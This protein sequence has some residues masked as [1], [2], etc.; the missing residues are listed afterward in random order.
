MAS[1]TE[2]F[3]GLSSA[4]AKTTPARSEPSRH[5]P[6][7]AQSQASPPTED[8]IFEHYIHSLNP[9]DPAHG[10]TQALEF[11]RSKELAR[12]LFELRD[13][14]MS[15]LTVLDQKLRTTFRD[16][17]QK[18]PL[19]VSKF[20][21]SIHARDTLR[22]L[23]HMLPTLILSHGKKVA[24]T[25]AKVFMK[26][27]WK[28]VWNK[29][30]SQGVVRQDKLAQAPQTATT[31]STN[32]VDVLAQKYARAGNLSKASQTICSTLI[33]ALKP[34]TLDKLKAKNPQDSTDFDSR[35]WPTA[36]EIDALRRDHVWQKIEAESFS[37]KKIKQFFARC[38]PL[39]A[40][41]VDSWRPREHIAWMLND[42][43][44]MFHDF[45]R[46]QLILHYVQ[47][48]FYE[49]HLS[50]AVGGKFFE[51]ENPNDSVRLVVIS[52]TWR[53]APAS[54]SVAEV[55]SDVANFL[56][57][58]YDNFLQFA[59]QKNGVTRCAQ[60][61]QLVASNWEAQTVDNPLVVMQLDIINMFCSVKMQAQFDVL[62]E[63]ASTSYDNGN[64]RD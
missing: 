35:H 44:K 32:Q 22:Y 34:D 59:C 62:A 63:M 26:G 27:D 45:I 1:V 24:I 57:S 17:L 42:E 10:W 2:S 12:E 36:E 28:S 55:N 38:S 52:S 3:T 37:I 43:D 53:R 39:S 41:D 58:T 30:R 56:M 11:L 13:F 51:L 31:R 47:G 50:E 29:C 25:H 61:T 40:Q 7:S 6:L 49:G 64:V 4:G 33:P 18:V 20:E 16:C 15:M 23:A 14:S 46:T 19:F 48:D 5:Q 21:D 8:N 9:S 54:L 60:L